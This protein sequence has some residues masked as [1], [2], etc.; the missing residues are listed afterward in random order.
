MRDNV[1]EYPRL[2][3]LEP[4]TVVVM[5]GGK[6]NAE[7][8]HI[9]SFY[10]F[11]ETR[12]LVPEVHLVWNARTNIVLSKRILEHTS[13]IIHR[14]VQN[15]LNNRYRHWKSIT[16]KSVLLLDDDT[17]VKNLSVAVRVHRRN[18]D[19]IICFWARAHHDSDG[20]GHYQ[21]KYRSKGLYSVGTGQGSL[22]LTSWMKSFYLDKRLIKTRMFIDK[23][24]PTCED[25]A[26]HMYVSNNT[27]MP[28]LLVDSGQIELRYTKKSGMSS[29]DL[30]WGY[31]R[32]LCLNMFV[33]RVYAGVMPL[34]YSEFTRPVGIQSMASYYSETARSD[35]EHEVPPARHF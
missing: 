10:L 27:G 14:E 24:K 28:P 2:D 18:P 22:L 20:N 3:C 17:L 33:K 11:N 13:L 29:L 8:E 9:L 31:K 5:S 25:I 32:L 12:R 15:T 34:R 35:V 30:N 26:L 1:C 21:Y 19:R 4:V 23:N 16:T 7:L 6:R